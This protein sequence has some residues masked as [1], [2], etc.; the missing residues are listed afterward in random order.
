VSAQASAEERKFGYHWPVMIAVI[1]CS[2][3]NWW[4]GHEIF[5]RITICG[6]EW[7][8]TVGTYVW[9]LW[10]L[11]A[12]VTWGYWPFNAIKNWWAR[13]VALL[14]ASWLLSVLSWYVSSLFVDLKVYGFPIIANLFFWIVVT[15]FS[16]RLWQKLPPLKKAILDLLLWYSLAILTIFCLPKPGQ[17]PAW[18][19]VPTQWLLGSGIFAYLSKDMRESEA[20]ILFWILNLFV[21]FLTVAIASLLGHFTFSLEDP[22]H[23]LLGGYSLEFL[24]WFGA[25]CSFNWSIFV[26]FEGWPWRKIKPPVLG[27]TLGFITVIIIQVIVTLCSIEI[28]RIIW[29][30]M[31]PTDVYYKLQAFVLAY[32][33]VEWGFAI[34][35]AFPSKRTGWPPSWSLGE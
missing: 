18:W 13:G 34:P 7:L 33:G 22:Y 26:I 24:I 15:D 19:F 17:I 20:G 31:S 14:A 16:F 10:W 25:A 3:L 27:A 4:L 12:F 1:V 35:L 30:P 6:L 11:F 32:A 2:V 29:P 21:V 28:C 9:A 23:S 8:D 5:T